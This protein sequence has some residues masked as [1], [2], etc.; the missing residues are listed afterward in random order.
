MLCFWDG[1]MGRFFEGLVW[2]KFKIMI[3]NCNYFKRNWKFR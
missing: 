3:I 2:G 1:F